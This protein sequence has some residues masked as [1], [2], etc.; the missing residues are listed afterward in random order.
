MISRQRAQPRRGANRTPNG[1]QSVYTIVVTPW[2]RKKAAAARASVSGSPTSSPTTSTRS[3]KLEFTARR[4]LRS[5]E[6]S[7]K[8]KWSEWFDKEYFNSPLAR[9]KWRVFCTNN[10]VVRLRE[11]IYRMR[12]SVA[13]K[14]DESLYVTTPSTAVRSAESEV[15]NAVNSGGAPLS[16]GELVSSIAERA[17]LSRSN[18]R[19]AVWRLISAGKIGLS[20]DRK[21]VARD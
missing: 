14:T 7:S 8:T 1:I 15:Q 21:I 18:V 10:A 2:R 17:S 11:G 5:L 12:S 20:S 4:L 16:M 3:S 9:S 13:Q 6:N 19:E